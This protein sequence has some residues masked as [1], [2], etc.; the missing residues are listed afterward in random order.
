MKGSVRRRPN[1]TWEYR[2]DAGA[3]AL[4]GRRTIRTKSG[5]DTKREAS[6]ALGAAVTAHERGRSVSSSAQTVAT[7]LNHW[8]APVQASLRPTTWVHYRDYMN[9]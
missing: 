4:T 2:F 8:H 9:A 1:G 3:H 5:F 6:Q 7:F